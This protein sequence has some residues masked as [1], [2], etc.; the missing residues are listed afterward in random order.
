MVPG[1]RYA[2]YNSETGEEVYSG[3]FTITFSAYQPYGLLNKKS[4]DDLESDGAEQYCGILPDDM[5]P[6]VPTTS[7]TNFLMYNCGTQRCATVFRVSGTANAGLTITNNTNGTSCVLTSLPSTGYLEIDG[8]YG[9][10]KWVHGNNEDFAFNYHVSG[11]I[12]LV[13][14]MGCE[15]DLVV[16]YTSGSTSVTRLIQKFDERFVGKYIYLDGGWKK[17]TA[18]ALDGTATIN[19]APSHTGTAQTKAVTMNEISIAGTGI[20][21]TRLEADYFPVIA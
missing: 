8:R 15:E 13:P 9:S 2:V 11:F 4:Y 7:S 6:A 12:S 3:T 16:N 19:T 20:A 5:M 17:I 1:K 21:L 10:I 18:V 14:Y